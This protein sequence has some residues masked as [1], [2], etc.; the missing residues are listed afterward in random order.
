MFDTVERR[1]E[2]YTQGFEACSDHHAVGRAEEQ[3]TSAQKVHRL[4][5]I[6]FLQ[7]GLRLLESANSE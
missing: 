3:K 2:S 6:Y 4:E 7:S 5:F 1:A